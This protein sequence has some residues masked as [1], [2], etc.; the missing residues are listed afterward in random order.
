MENNNN[1]DDSSQKNNFFVKFKE[2]I[3]NLDTNRK[4]IIMIGASAIM[5]AIVFTDT[6][7]KKENVQ[8]TPIIEQA[9][10]GEIKTIEQ[11]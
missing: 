3:K 7:P 8:Q 11:K 9:P 10:V 4:I 6:Q 2:D 1:N 5:G